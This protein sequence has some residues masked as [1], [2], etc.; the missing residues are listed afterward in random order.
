MKESEKYM[1]NEKIGLKYELVG[2]NYYSCPEAPKGGKFGMQNTPTLRLTIIHNITVT[3]PAFER[4]PLC[5]RERVSCFSHS[6]ETQMNPRRNDPGGGS[7]FM[8]SVRP[9]S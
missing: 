7:G 2:D 4:E 9:F 3:A 1:I 8:P 5:Y 6:F